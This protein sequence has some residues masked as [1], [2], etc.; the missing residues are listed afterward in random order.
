MFDEEVAKK[1]KL[2]KQRDPKR[3]LFV[4]P[5]MKWRY[6][7]R[8][9]KEVSPHLQLLYSNDDRVLKAVA[10][11]TRAYENRKRKLDAA[12]L[13]QARRFDLLAEEEKQR[14]KKLREAAFEWFV[15]LY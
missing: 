13:M 6:L 10:V 5:T 4:Q 12:V 9:E 15:C 8:S 3:K 1:A 7:T 14:L 2:K 11:A